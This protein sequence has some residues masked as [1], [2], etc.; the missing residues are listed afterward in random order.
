MT[1]SR[2]VSVVLAVKNAV[3]TI[4]LALESAL[5]QT[6]E[7]IEI[8]VIDGGS[9]DGTRAIIEGHADRLAYW[10]SK[11]DAGIADAWN[12]GIA[13][14][15]GD[16]IIL[17]NADDALRHDFVEKALE[18]LPVGV[19]GVAFG[20]TL[21]LDEQGRTVMRVNGNFDPRHLDRG[22]GF[23]HTSCAVTRAAYELVGG[24]DP[25]FRIAVD[26]DWL[27]RAHRAR[28]PFVRHES[29]NYMR[30]GGVSDRS[31]DEG[32]REYGAQVAEHG[33]GSAPWSGRVRVSLT[34]RALHLLGL[35]RWIRWRRQVALLALAAFHLLYNGIPSWTI[36][37]WLLR[38]W[39]IDVG[40]ASVIHSPVRF[41]SRGRVTIGLRTVINRDCVI[42]NRMRVHVGNDVSIGQGTRIFTLG[43]DIDD[44]YFASTGKA[45]EIEDRAVTFAGAMLMPGA[46]MREGSVAL[47]GA[48][49]TGEVEPW[50][51]VGGVPA[52][53][54]RT[55]S[56]QQRYVLAEPYHFQV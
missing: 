55:R 6:Y 48:I 52:R 49:V 42:D 26:T 15:T 34:N 35:A 13:R 5:Q 24:F 28:V 3:A 4:E 43:H 20:D 32:R 54:V 31:H 19:P 27:L 45:V 14:T 18:V 56:Q 36:R 17:L 16:V 41:L 51:V 38:M 47:A 40:E 22:F 37:R 46:R 44:P 53:F 29:L 39:N 2:L 50:T 30:L 11:P 21:L 12:R 7:P 23:W 33:A 8:I 10:H 25:K 9:T 1:T